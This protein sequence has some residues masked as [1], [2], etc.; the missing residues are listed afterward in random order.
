MAVGKNDFEHLKL[1]LERLLHQMNNDKY[2]DLETSVDALCS[3]TRYF[4]KM[5][6]DY[7]RRVKLNKEFDNEQGEN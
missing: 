4:Y 2:Y 6:G 5:G 1:S 3:I 7:K